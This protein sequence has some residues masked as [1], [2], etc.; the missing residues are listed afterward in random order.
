MATMT[1]ISSA[2][3]MKDSM[4]TGPEK[5]DSWGSCDLLMIQTPLPSYPPVLVLSTTLSP[6]NAWR[7]PALMSSALQ[8][9]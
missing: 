4:S 8:R 5:G 7:V 1:A 9:T 3:G 6:G 2:S